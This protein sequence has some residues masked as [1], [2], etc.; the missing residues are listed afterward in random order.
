MS[1]LPQMQVLEDGTREWWL[2]GL[3]HRVDGPAREGDDGARS[4]WLNGKQ[5]RVDGPAWEWADGT[6][7]WWL[8]DE[9]LEFGDYV[10]RIFPLDS[11]EKIMFILQWSGK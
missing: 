11:Q 4:W 9:K 7:E 2:N 8:N 1:E 5:H 3:R 6:R 10:N